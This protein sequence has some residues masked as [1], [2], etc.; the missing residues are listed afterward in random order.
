MMGRMLSRILV[1]QSIHRRGNTLLLVTLVIGGSAAAPPGH[2][3]QTKPLIPLGDQ[4]R[5]LQVLWKC[6]WQDQQTMN[7]A[8]QPE[9]VLDH[10]IWLKKLRL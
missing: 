8:S 7:V 3:E 9:Q 2:K 1:W 10:W 4:V 6:C 5:R